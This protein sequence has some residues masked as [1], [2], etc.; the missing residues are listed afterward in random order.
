VGNH[1]SFP[2]DQFSDDFLVDTITQKFNQNNYNDWKD[3]IGDSDEHK[4][5]VE[6]GGY[7]SSP[8]LNNK[9]L[10]V[11][12][13]TSVYDPGNVLIKNVGAAEDHF[14]Q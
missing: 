12:L 8:I 13:N 10:L 6:K 3:W 4:Q 14:G 9:V 2:I 7:Y 11:S 5:S 1:D